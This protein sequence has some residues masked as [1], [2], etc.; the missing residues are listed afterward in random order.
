MWKTPDPGGPSANGRDAI[1]AAQIRA[2]RAQIDIAFVD[3]IVACSMRV[4]PA[5]HDAAIAGHRKFG[6]GAPTISGGAQRRASQPRR[7]PMAL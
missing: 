4:L 1:F 6:L 7:P 2:I 3:D 5:A